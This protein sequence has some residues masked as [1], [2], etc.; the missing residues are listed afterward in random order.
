MNK[1][2]NRKHDL[3]LIIFSLKKKTNLHVDYYYTIINSA[4]KSI[5]AFKKIRKFYPDHSNIKLYNQKII[6]LFIC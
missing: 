4:Q 5:N 3:Y 1:L 2:T 6:C